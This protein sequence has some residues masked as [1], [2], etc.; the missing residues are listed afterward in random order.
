MD[1]LAERVDRALSRS[2]PWLGQGLP[3][4]VLKDR[5]G[6][7]RPWMTV[8]S[9]SEAPLDD[10]PRVERG[11]LTVTLGIDVDDFEGVTRWIESA[12]AEWASEIGFLRIRSGSS[13]RQSDSRAPILILR[14][15]TW[16]LRPDGPFPDS[17]TTHMEGEMR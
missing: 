13:E 16:K 1:T 4:P 11:T 2:H 8:R 6:G 14:L 12:L 7:Q 15:R 10:A 5:P 9:S 3:L 17:T